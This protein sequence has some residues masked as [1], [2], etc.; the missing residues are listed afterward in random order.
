MNLHWIHCIENFSPFSIFEQLSLALKNSFP[1]VFHCIDYILFIIR[2][3][4][5]TCAACPQKQIWPEILHCIEIFLSFRI[6]E[7]LCLA[8]NFSLYWIYFLHSGIL[9]NLRLLWKTECT[10]N[11]L[12]ECI[13]FIIKDFWATCACPKKQSCPEIFY[14]FEI[15]FIIQEF[16][17][18][19]ACPEIF[20]A[21][22]GSSSLPPPLY[23]Y[24]PMV[25]RML[26]KWQF[27]NGMNKPC[28]HWMDCACLV[29]KLGVTITTKRSL[30]TGN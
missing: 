1:E 28:A 23:A 11:S 2:D 21:G 30:R 27:Q 14:C 26:L 29:Q 5:A 6:F 12:A 7:Q 13:F 16:W 3:F 18:T 15:F 8:W 24:G 9:S 4:W 25:W 17:A 20:Q 19:C 22:G 10:L